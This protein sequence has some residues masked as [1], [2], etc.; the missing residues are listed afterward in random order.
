MGVCAATVATGFGLE[1]D[2]PSCFDP[3]SGCE[4]KPVQT[5]LISKGLEFETFKFR[6]VNLLPN[7]DE[8]ERVAIAHPV[9]NQAIVAEFFRHVG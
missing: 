7:A 2:S 3:L 4:R 8:F 1:P 5:S 6:I 9:V